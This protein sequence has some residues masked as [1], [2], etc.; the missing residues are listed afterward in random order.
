MPAKAL[1]SYDVATARAVA[2]LA[3]LVEYAAPLLV[4]GGMLVAWKG[5][6]DAGEERAGGC[7]RR[8]ARHDALG[9]CCRCSPL[10]A[11]GTG[12]CTYTRSCG[13]RRPAT[14]AARA[15]RAS[16]RWE[17]GKGPNLLRQGQAGIVWFDGEPSAGWRK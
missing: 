10:P 3:T 4:T 1:E 13:R 9:G 12:T 7:G 15:W 14:L 17:E 11:A 16:A 8:D 6:R 2:P 5:R